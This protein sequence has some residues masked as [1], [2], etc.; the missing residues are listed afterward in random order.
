MPSGGR[1]KWKTLILA[2]VV[3]F[4]N[5]IVNFFIAIARR[6]WGVFL[7]ACGVALLAE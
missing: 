3:I 6:W 7:V 5:A 2:T 4:S 1:L